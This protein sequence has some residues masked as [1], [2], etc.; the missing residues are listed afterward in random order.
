MKKV[1]FI[2]LVVISFIFTGC[3]NSSSIDSS[4]LAK[5][6]IEQEDQP[7][8]EKSFVLLTTDEK[9]ISFNSTKEGLSFDEFKGQKA[10]LLDIFATWCPPCIESIPTLKEIKEK[11]KD[12]LEI[13]S[14]LFQDEK[15]VEEMKAFIKEY[16][17]NYPITM[18]EENQKIIEDLNVQ[19]VP[20][21]FLFSKDGRFVHRFVGKASKEELEKYL[22]IAIEN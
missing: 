7:F 19:K 9:F 21:M 3:D 17:I 11:N 8:E 13:V 14:V 1:F 2:G 6:K 20:E 12:S 15:T 4:V 16:E 22:K 18:G 10:V 5:V